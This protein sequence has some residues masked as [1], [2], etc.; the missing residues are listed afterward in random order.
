MKYVSVLFFGIIL[1]SA[2]CSNNNDKDCHNTITIVN[3]SDKTLFFYMSHEYPDTAIINYN[4]SDAGSYYKI[5]KNSSHKHIKR[6]C[7]EYDFKINPKLMYFIFD[8]QVLETVPWDTVKANYLVLK[9]YDLTLQ[10]LNDMNWSITY[11]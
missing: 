3:N 2:T 8:A 4:P 6:D 9:R 1:I 7:F 5:E 11:P 10:D